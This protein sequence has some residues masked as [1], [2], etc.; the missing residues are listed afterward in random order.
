MY[1]LVITWN[2]AIGAEHSKRRM[3]ATMAVV[4]GI[5]L[6]FVIV[7]WMVPGMQVPDDAPPESR[8]GLVND[9]RITIVLIGFGILVTAILAVLWARFRTIEQ[10]IWAT[11]SA[12]LGD[13]FDRAIA[14]L[15]EENEAVIIGGIYSLERVARDS[16]VEHWK[17]MEIMTAY[18][19]FAAGIEENSEFQGAGG[20][21]VDQ[22]SVKAS[23]QA[24]LDV[25]G[26]RDR[27][28]ETTNQ[29]IDL[30]NTDLRGANLQ[31]THLE[32]A[33][34]FGSRLQWTDLRSAHMENAIMWGVNLEGANIDGGHLEG[35]NFWEA[36]FEGAR[37]SGAHLQGASLLNVN[38]LTQDQLEG[39]YIDE[40][41]VLPDDILASDTFTAHDAEKLEQ[42]PNTTSQSPL[43]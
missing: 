26:R 19:R 2:S 16:A 13:R 22:A 1:R 37:I 24:I 3:A 25:L 18:V 20:A 6:G 43:A 29:R 12:R 23:V 15:T 39:A 4:M 14:Q 9:A 27:F 28:Q 30:R 10:S 42:L 17:V 11:R 21:S 31:G 33:I 36:N 38:G 32:R 5:L 7:M 35:A 41:T 34:L 8:A 40:S